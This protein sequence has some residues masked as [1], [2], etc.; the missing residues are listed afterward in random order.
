MHN[1]TRAL[2]TTSVQINT[3]RIVERVFLNLQ[4]HLS[5]FHCG[6]DLLLWG[7]HLHHQGITAVHDQK[8]SWRTVALLWVEKQ[9]PWLGR[10]NMFVPSTCER[11]MNSEGLI[12]A[13]GVSFQ[14]KGKSCCDGQRSR[15]LIHTY[16][17]NI[18]G[19]RDLGHSSYMCKRFSNSWHTVN[20]QMVTIMVTSLH[21][22]T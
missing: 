17:W 13:T 6:P 20:T 19:W 9:V 11:L 18:P 14:P 7:L 15:G 8:F 1:F 22:T 21:W 16:W 10:P 2:K 4:A 5:T 12:K 3:N